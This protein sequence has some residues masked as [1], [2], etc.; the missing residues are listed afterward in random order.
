MRPKSP[1]T[2]R[3]VR[4]LGADGNPLRRPSD[5][6]ESALRIA[7]LLAFLI[8]GPLLVSAT[9]RLAEVAGMRT[10][11]QQ[12]SWHQV[13]AILLNSSPK[14]FPAYGSMTTYWVPA[15]WRAPS[16]ATRLGDVLSPAGAP[17]GASVRIWIDGSG[18]VTGG[19]PLTEQVALLRVILIELGTLIGL[20][21]AM[22]IVVRLFRRLLIRRRIVNWGI[23]WAAFGPRWTTRR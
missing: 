3:A 10:M 6:L 23:E 18:R 4:W 22:L 5:H 13:G 16:G 20:A 2:A 11:Q 12:R 9:G 15:R 14:P 19:H 7:L 8:G 21:L 17:A 1:V